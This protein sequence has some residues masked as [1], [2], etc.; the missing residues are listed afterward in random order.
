MTTRIF[1]NIPLAEKQ[2]LTLDT[3][4]SH[5]LL[6]VLRCKIGDK[7]IIFNGEDGEFNAEII[8]KEKNHVLVFLNS[9]EQINRE[10]PLYIH[11]AQAISRGEKMDFTIQKAVELGVNKITPLITEFCNVKL[12]A[13]R[14][15]KKLQH[16]QNIIINACEQSG[17]TKIPEIESPIEFKKWL[18]TK[19]ETTKIILDPNGEKN[20]SDLKP[21]DN[22]ICL[23][24][25]SEG[26]F[27]ENEI[28]FAKQQ[29][30]IATKFGPRILRTE[31]MALAII[32]AIQN[33]YG[34]FK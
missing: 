23:L 22:K 30:F 5:H 24:I 1:Q 6:N 12:N 33:R 20:L 17:R 13:E 14:W 19:L 10:S 26:G 8:D 11:L 15:Q 27:S 2:H 28:N 9:F 31:T 3:A 32:V 25:G 18:G 7:I 4:T 34:D 29:N 21:T 16:W